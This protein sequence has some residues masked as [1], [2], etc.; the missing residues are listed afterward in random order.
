M[1]GGFDQFTRR[2]KVGREVFAD[3]IA[4]GQRED[5]KGRERREGKERNGMAR[6]KVRIGN[7]KLEIEN[8]VMRAYAKEVAR[9]NVHT[10]QGGHDQMIPP[11]T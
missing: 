7:W 4:S 6:W 10:G 5:F 2:F 3:N 1:G 9:L 11:A 8:T